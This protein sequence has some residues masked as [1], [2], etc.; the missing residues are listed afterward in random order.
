MSQKRSPR[1]EEGKRQKEASTILQSLSCEF[2]LQAQ[3]AVISSGAA[4][5]FSWASDAFR[6]EALRPHRQLPHISA[7][8]FTQLC[9]NVSQKGEAATVLHL[10]TKTAELIKG[11]GER[12]KEPK[13]Q[14]R[15]KTLETNAPQKAF[16]TA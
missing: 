9:N 15:R 13:L 5:L 6:G 4:R 14:K 12:K 7:G 8:R 16:F 3:S 2:H 10:S 11:R 1:D